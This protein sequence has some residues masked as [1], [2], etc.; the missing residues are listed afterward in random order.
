MNGH[1]P[2]AW[3]PRLQIPW[4]HALPFPLPP[5]S[6]APLPGSGG[7]PGVRRGPGLGPSSALPQPWDSALPRN[8]EDGGVIL[9]GAWIHCLPG[10]AAPTPLTRAQTHTS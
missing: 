2:P 5:S 8:L 3:S 10:S 7:P 1:P 4:L 9:Q 6:L